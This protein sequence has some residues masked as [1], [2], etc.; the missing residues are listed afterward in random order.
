MK[1][2]CPRNIIKTLS[3]LR[4][5][6]ESW[7]EYCHGSCAK[8]KWRKFSTRTK[9]PKTNFSLRSPCWERVLDGRTCPFG[10]DNKTSNETVFLQSTS[11]ITWQSNKKAKEYYFHRFHQHHLT[12]T[13]YRWREGLKSFWEEKL[14]VIRYGC[15]RMMPLGWWYRDRGVRCVWLCASSN[16]L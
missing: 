10:G 1:C 12:E 14:P 9:G 13:R 8:K 16:Q 6:N 2:L 4:E 7:P 15:P 5:R 3:V 11:A